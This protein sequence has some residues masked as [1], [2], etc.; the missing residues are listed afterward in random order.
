MRPFVRHEFLLS[1]LPPLCVT[2]AA[3][4][5][6]SEDS[7]VILRYLVGRSIPYVV[8]NHFQNTR[9]TDPPIRKQIAGALA[10]SGV[11]GVAVPDFLAGRFINVSDGIDAEFFDRVNV[12]PLKRDIKK[13]LV[14]LPSRV[15]QGK[16]HLEA[17]RMLAR[18]SREGVPATL[19][20]AGRVESRR[21]LG[22]ILEAA[23][24]EGLADNVI[25][26]G[27]LS[28]EELRNWYGASDVV[29]LT[30]HS[31]GLGRVLLEAQAMQ[32]PVVAYDVGGVREAVAHGDSGYLV[33]VGDVA[34]LSERIRELLANSDRRLQM[35]KHGRQ[36]V[37]EQFS[38]D[39]LAGRHERLYAEAVLASR[40]FAKPGTRTR[41]TT[42]WHE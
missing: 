20:F 14:L 2:L 41:Q 34:A 1:Q 33:P 21:L 42:E 32:T 6:I 40:P 11:S 29:L 4:H 10:V 23:N 24:L 9:L 36:R 30:T 12:R 13:P 16:G 37:L 7:N 8:V 18:L 22:D 27:E 28:A 39:A 17:L 35:G 3:F 19:A 26:T 5:W 38:L 25:V 15:T 31:E